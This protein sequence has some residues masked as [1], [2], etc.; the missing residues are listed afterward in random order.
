[1]I[2]WMRRTRATCKGELQAAGRGRARA[3]ARPWRSSAWRS[4]PSC[5]RA[6]R[7]PSSCSRPSSDATNPTPAGLGAVLGLVARRRD[8]LRDLPRRRAHQPLAL[9]PPHRA[10]SSCWWPRGCSPPRCTRAARGRLGQRRPEPGA[11]PQRG[12]SARARCCGVAA[13]RHARPPAA[14]DG[15][16]GGR[17]AA[18]RRADAVSSSARAAAR[19]PAPRATRR[20]RRRGDGPRAARRPLGGSAATSRR[21]TSGER[22][23]ADRQRGDHRRR[24]RA[25]GAEGSPSGPTTFVVTNKG[26]RGVTE[27]EVV[28]GGRDPGRGRERRR[29]AAPSASRSPSSRAATRCAARRRHER[30]AR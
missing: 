22:R 25:G 2:V 4:S 24:L 9:L 23:R 6:S 20:R 5:A 10:S 15:G 27:F 21:S 26:S 30:P 17:L 29:R 13:H 19:P 8:R 16:R 3:R 14:A 28:K 7:P 12:S 11:R 1:M 18:L